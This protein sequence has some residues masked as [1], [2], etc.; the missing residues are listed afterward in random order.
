[1]VPSHRIHNSAIQGLRR[2]D[3]SELIIARRSA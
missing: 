3:L 1:M 2:S